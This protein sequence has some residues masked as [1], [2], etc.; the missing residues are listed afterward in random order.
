MKPFTNVHSLRFKIFIIVAASILVGFA[1]FSIFTLRHQQKIYMEDLLFN[2][3]SVAE[4]IIN[5]LEHDM[6][7]NDTGGISSTLQTIAR[8]DTIQS[9]RIYSHAGWVWASSLSQEEGVV[10]FTRPE[11]RQCSGCHQG[12]VRADP[13]RNF[14]TYNVDSVDKCMMN[15]IVPIPNRPS[16]STAS[17]HV[18][19]TES[20]MLGFLNLSV[21]RKRVQASLRDSQILIVVVSLLLVILVP[22]LIMLTITRYVVRPLDNL[23]EGTV[24]VARGELDVN[25]PVHSKDEIGKLAI[26]FNRMVEQVQQ[27]QK[28]LRTM[29][30]NLERRVEQKAE[31]LKV[32]QR[33][34]IQTEKMSSLGRLAA[35]IA[36]EI[37]NPISGLVVFI[38]LLQQPL[39]RETLSEDD[40]N[41]MIKRLGLMESEAKRCGKIVSELLAFSH[42]EKKMVR[43][44]M[45]EIVGRTVSIMQLRTRDR[46]VD[47]AVH[48]AEDIPQ[49]V[50]DP[51]KIQQVIMNLLQNAAEAMP[52]G[53]EVRITGRRQ[54][55]PEAVI[56][57]VKD[58]GIGI[59][60]SHLPHV[61]EP[62]YSSKDHGQSVGIGLFVVYGVVE[63]HNGTIHVESREGEG[64]T[65]T[66][67]LPV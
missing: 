39:D 10:Q 13:N 40:R 43:C 28:E 65:F 21:C 23:V 47:I 34:I 56:L 49:L 66:I 32:A 22:G 57:E 24:R 12:G 58:N 29:N 59:P 17:C 25:L 64:T 11:S 33:Q 2:A 61:F 50:C 55:E 54:V 15:V 5:S 14:L 52:E 41:K 3:Q 1:A 67:T 38:N 37:N 26:S 45:Q 31:K 63:Q 4:T 8:Q 35:V 27:F 19:D 9:L 7:A 60:A 36:H 62:F 6:M 30:E 16:C 53:G 51:G 48:I 18:H 42:E 44:S 20:P 46:N